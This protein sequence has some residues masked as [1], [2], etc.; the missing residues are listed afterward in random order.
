LSYTF[1]WREGMSWAHAFRYGAQSS[2]PT[3]PA[4]GKP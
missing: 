2:T 3:T 4:G 1:T